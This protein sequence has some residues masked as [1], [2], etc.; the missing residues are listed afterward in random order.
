MFLY[1]LITTRLIEINY[2]LIG[3]CCVQYNF[4]GYSFS[5][6][7]LQGN[8]ILRPICELRQKYRFYSFSQYSMLLKTMLW[9]FCSRSKLTVKTPDFVSIQDGGDS[10]LNRYCTQGK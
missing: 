3:F 5:R 9:L 4:T 2:I 10:A 1:N 7:E 8:V 6:H